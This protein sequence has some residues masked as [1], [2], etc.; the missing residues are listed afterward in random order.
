[1]KQDLASLVVFGTSV[2]AC[3]WSE[4]S[5]DV[6]IYEARNIYPTEKQK[7]KQSKLPISQNSWVVHIVSYL[8]LGIGRKLCTNIVVN[9]L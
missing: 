5:G 1:M 4:L 7:Q 3:W 6:P 8:K 9:L 2:L